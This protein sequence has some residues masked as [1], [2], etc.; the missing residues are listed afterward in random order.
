MDQVASGRSLA[1]RDRQS[2]ALVAAFRTNRQDCRGFDQ[3]MLVK[4]R[5]RRMLFVLT[6]LGMRSK[7]PGGSNGQGKS[8]CIGS[9]AVDGHGGSVAK[10]S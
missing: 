7:R 2:R 3:V 10:Q 1:A 8:D 5:S 9:A 6:W 4:L